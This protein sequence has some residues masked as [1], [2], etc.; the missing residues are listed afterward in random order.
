M[1]LS[2]LESVKM[3][4]T[5]LNIDRSVNLKIEKKEM[6]IIENPVINIRLNEINNKFFMDN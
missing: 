4:H 1:I 5:P 2:Y 3:T 6:N